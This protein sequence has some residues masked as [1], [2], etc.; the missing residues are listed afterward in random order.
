M[1]AARLLATE[2]F[3]AVVPDCLGV[4][5]HFTDPSPGEM[6][7][8]ARA[9][10]RWIR[11]DF[12]WSGTEREKGV[13]DFTDWDHLMAA[14]KP[15][16]IRA[17][18]VLSYS[19]KYYDNGMSPASDEGR[20]A[21]ARWAVTAAHH[22]RGRGIVWEMYNEPNIDM[23]WKPHPNAEHYA[24]LAL[25]V[26]QALRLAESDEVYIGP[27]EAGIDEL[28]DLEFLETCF[29]AGLLDYW[30][31][32]SVHPYRETGPETVVSEYQRARKLI[33]RYTPHGKHIPILS[34]EWGYE[35]KLHDS[36]F[37][38]PD[39]VRQG[40]MLA[41]MFLTN[42][43]NNV[44]LSIWY[45]WHDDGTDP[46][47]KEH[48][49]GVVRGPYRAG[50]T[51]VYEP[52]PAYLAM[53]T[54]AHELSGC[55]FHKRLA[56]GG[57]NDYVLEFGKGSEIR[58]AVWTATASHAVAIAV[59]AGKYTAVG[60]TGQTLPRLSADA[61]GLSVTLTDAPT[62]LTPVASLHGSHR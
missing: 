23:F 2:P 32:V 1:G 21:F 43:A 33:D 5:I 60:H 39:D 18:A 4:N 37:K 45:D 59:P 10:F 47:N 38:G 50:Q 49:F 40:K 27:A 56:V 13:Y 28:E 53:Q 16:H 48:H 26:G 44:P 3:E 20:A 36:D 29:K 54:L 8:V 12:S 14:L 24:K 31:G 34:G 57:E 17:M 22:F 61:G 11:T 7:M 58:L 46:H 62:Y 42:L 51:L 25:K 30:A 55:R 6:E 52:K 35:W 9:G 19:N 41:R 15:Y